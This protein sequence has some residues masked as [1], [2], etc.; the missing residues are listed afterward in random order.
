MGHGRN[1]VQTYWIRSILKQCLVEN[2]YFGNMRQ[3][4]KIIFV[5]EI[6]YSLWE[7]WWWHKTLVNLFSSVFC[8]RLSQGIRM[9]VRNIAIL[10]DVFQQ[11][12]YAVT[13]TQIC[14]LLKLRCDWLKPNL[15]LWANLWLVLTLCATVVVLLFYWGAYL[16]SLESI[17]VIGWNLTLS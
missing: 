14:C 8:M 9:S 12:T 4:W 7:E 5:I 17:I 1:W 3:Q 13:S 2:A 10:Y 11:Y 6:R 15:P 16:L